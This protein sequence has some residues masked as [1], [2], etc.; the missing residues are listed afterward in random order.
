MPNVVDKHTS[1]YAIASSSTGP[2]AA[3]AITAIA[4]TPAART[5][6]FSTSTGF[7][8]SVTWNVLP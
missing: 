3:T 5:A 8:G 4:Q 7:T 6:P 1:A 2:A